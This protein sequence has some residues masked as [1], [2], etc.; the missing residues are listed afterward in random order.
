ML[1]EIV[2]AAQGPGAHVNTII[3]QL[4]PTVWEGS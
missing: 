3:N 1:I 4:D 2:S